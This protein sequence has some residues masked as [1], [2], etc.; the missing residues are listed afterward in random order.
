[1]DSQ[2]STLDEFL[3]GKARLAAPVVE[4]TFSFRVKNFWVLPSWEFAMFFAVQ[5]LV[6]GIKVSR[7]SGFQASGVEDVAVDHS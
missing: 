2:N 3:E 7:R 6:I 4:W 1:M 5:A